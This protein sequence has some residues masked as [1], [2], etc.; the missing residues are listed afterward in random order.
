[1]S[2]YNLLANIKRSIAEHQGCL[3][4]QVNVFVCNELLVL[5]GGFESVTVKKEK[6]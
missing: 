3:V 1:V 5:P 6:I 4:N 2:H